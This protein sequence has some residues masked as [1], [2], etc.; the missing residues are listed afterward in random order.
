M[1]TS[2][3]TLR[4]SCG[5]VT[6]QPPGG[7][8]RWATSKGNAELQGVVPRV[9]PTLIQTHRTMVPSEAAVLTLRWIRGRWFCSEE[10]EPFGL[11][12]MAEGT[13]RI[14]TGQAGPTQQQ[15]TGYRGGGTPGLPKD[16]TFLSKDH[17]RVPPT[18]QPLG[19]N[20]M[21]QGH[22]ATP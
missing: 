11:V 14:F 22:R 8:G 20:T 18:S 15:H 4:N 2:P 9:S 7:T 17:S 1:R 3:T 6:P 10:G 16:N 12:A 21:M 13:C 19:F 5:Y